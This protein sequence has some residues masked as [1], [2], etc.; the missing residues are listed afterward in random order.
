MG[1]FGKAIK[2]GIA[3][4]ALKVAQREM[5]KPQNQRKAR[6]LLQRVSRRG[7]QGRPGTH[8]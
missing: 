3:V 6:E 7:G 4:K 8:R 2:S 5:S 1:F